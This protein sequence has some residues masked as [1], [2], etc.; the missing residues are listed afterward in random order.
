MAIGCMAHAMDEIYH[1]ST[2]KERRTAA[3]TA[4]SPSS[5]IPE[6][7]RCRLSSSVSNLRLNPSW[8][9]NKQ[10]S[11]RV[12]AQQNRV[13]TSRRL[14][15]KHRNHDMHL[16]HNFIDFKKAFDR[17]RHEALLLML[18]KH[19]VHSN[20]V[21]LIGSLYENTSCRVLV[22]SNI[23]DWFH[24]TVG[25]RQGCLLSPCLFNIFLEQIMT[26]ALE[27][28]E[29]NVRIGGRSTNNLRFAGDIDLIA[30]SMKELAELTERLD[31]SASA[32]GMEIS[33]EKREI[34]VTPPTNEN[35][36]NIPITVSG[37]KLQS[38]KT[39]KYL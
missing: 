12:E 22:D 24:T 15:E 17:V 20:L 19:N 8:P 35:N 18:K 25:V 10:A 23:G 32:F 13:L 28:F 39:F 16:Y 29:G 2:T 5:A 30:G 14:I 1:S 9:K 37:G 6:K 34:M 31:K 36:T 3:I 21:H 33:A 27:S 26:E 38:I 11:A 7:S 4:L